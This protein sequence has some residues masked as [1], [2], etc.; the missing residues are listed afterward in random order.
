MES[1]LVA[2]RRV[3]PRATPDQRR[4]SGLSILLASERAR[5][6]HAGY[7]LYVDSSLDE[8]MSRSNAR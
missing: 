2:E 6:A 8:W 4:W 7:D 1:T 3:S 5:R